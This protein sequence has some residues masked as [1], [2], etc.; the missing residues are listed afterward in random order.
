MLGE[1]LTNLLVSWNALPPPPFFVG[2]SVHSFL[3]VVIGKSMTVFRSYRHLGHVILEV[4][5]ISLFTDMY[6]C[7]TIFC[8]PK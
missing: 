5:C 7:A 4:L 3:I 6:V 8:H 1:I 2:V